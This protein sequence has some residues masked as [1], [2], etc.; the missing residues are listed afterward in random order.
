MPAKLTLN[1]LA[2]NLILESNTPFSSGDFEKTIREKWRQE[3]PNS[4]LKKLKKKLFAH[5][6]LIE[7]NTDDF[8][9][10][11][12]ALQKI[13]N[14]SLSIR[15]NSFEINK[16][17]FFPGHRLIPFISS[18]KKESDLTFLCL[19]G[20][21]IPKQ[22]LPFLIEDII[23]YYQYS[24]PIHFPD[25]IKLNNWVL[26]KSYL[27]VTAWDITHV[28][29]QNQLK[30]G[31]FLCIKLVDYE[32]GVFQ[33][34]PYHK[35]KMPLAR[36]KMRSLF[37]SME[38]ILTKLC[39]IDSFCAT[40]LEKQLLCTLY[41]VDKSL[42]NIPAFSLIDFI[43]SLNELEVIGCEEGGGRLVSGS[44]IHLNKSV[45]E[46]T[47]RVSKGETGSLDKIFQD[48]KLAFN[49]DEFA[50]ILYTVMGSETYKL[51]SVF[52]ILFGGEGKVF[53]NQNQHEMFYQHLRE[54]LKK[55]CSDLKQP[56]S[57]AI[58]ALRD[59]TVS[60][61]LSLIETL[62]F[63]EKN[64]V[65]LKDLPQDLLGKIY[66]LD[67]FCRET[68]SHLADRTAIPKLKFI[69]DAKL[70]IKII[71]PHATALEEEIYSQL[72]FY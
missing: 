23:P 39:T 69:H 20:N 26:E 47:P 51:E 59:Q 5:D 57:K 49:K 68:L 6:Y 12:V 72:G 55:I 2:E 50:S 7:T 42:L 67:H 63:L 13:K 33:I 9:P 41:H 21:E 64:E 46:E 48:L 54:L 25:E 36:L 37:V 65:G 44:K 60:I 45:C 62:R 40:G 1:K 17:V 11:P 15:L 61:K 34:Q 18:E 56:E 24:S 66:D 52:N 71:L 35:N 22:K 14:L 70:A 30:E 28:I 19:D 32:K 43:E 27:L 38:K 3:I 53:N 29:H 16:K 58:S 31:D 4:I 10:I 8:L